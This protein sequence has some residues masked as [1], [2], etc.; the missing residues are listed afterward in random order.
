[1]YQYDKTEHQRVNRCIVLVTC[2]HVVCFSGGLPLTVFGS[3][4]NAVQ[5]PVIS[6]VI[7]EQR[8]HYY[9]VRPLLLS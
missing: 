3:N 8:Q 9:D 7:G 6:V 1:M 5:N 4:L 2:V